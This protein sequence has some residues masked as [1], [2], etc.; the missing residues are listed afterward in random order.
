MHEIMSPSVIVPSVGVHRVGVHRIHG[1]H[2]V[3]HHGSLISPA[4]VHGWLRPSVSAHHWGLIPSVSAHHRR[5][6]PSSVH[7]LRVASVDW[8]LVPSCVHRLV[9]THLI[10]HALAAPATVHA[11]QFEGNEDSAGPAAL[12]EEIDVL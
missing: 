5:L 3:V 7:R 12:V 11:L 2:W 9:V 1:V 4:V 10:S 8:R 6:V